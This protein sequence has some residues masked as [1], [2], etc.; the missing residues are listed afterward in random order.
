MKKWVTDIKKGYFKYRAI[1]GISIIFAVIVY[2]LMIT[3]MLTNSLDG[4]WNNFYYPGV[5]WPRMIGR[6]F[7]PI[8]TAPRYGLVCHSV[9]SLFTISLFTL[10]NIVILR[11]F[12]ISNKVISLL[13]S[14]MILTTPLVCDS[15]SYMFMS[16]SYGAAYFFAAL[17]ALFLIGLNKKNSYAD[18]V[19]G[20]F[21]ISV[22]MGC[23]QAY[24]NVT[25]T[26]LAMYIFYQ[27]LHRISI[28]EIGKT[29]VKSVAGILTGG[30]CYYLCVQIS[31]HRHN[32][33]LYSYQGA[34]KVGIKNILS[35]LPE[36]IP[37]AYSD[38]YSYFLSRNILKNAYG[39][40]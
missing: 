13:F 2:L 37:R 10:G 20:A 7:Q 32:L 16:P 5:I 35:S 26:L 6:W 39:V 21:A 18:I 19:L 31:L 17:A 3:Q 27:C 36:T 29:T 4:L 9:N 14:F 33:V 11:M 12:D 30:L 34:D 40:L 24:L 25:C 23:Y 1:F 38:F 15:L 28:K 8:L 22:S